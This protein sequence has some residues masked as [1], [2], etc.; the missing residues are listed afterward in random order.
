MWHHITGVSRPL[1][2]TVVTD[3]WEMFFF[4]Q[5]VPISSWWI[6][7][8]FLCVE[9]WGLSTGLMWG[10]LGLWDSRVQQKP[11]GDR[12]VHAHLSFILFSGFRW[13]LP[14]VPAQWCVYVKRYKTFS[15]LSVFIRSVFFLG[16]WSTAL[17]EPKFHKSSCFSYCDCF[18]LYKAIYSIGN[19][20][21]LLVGLSYSQT[22]WT[23]ISTTCE[24]FWILF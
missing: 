6:C 8:L 21:M 12:L 2:Q 18:M 5:P 14:F 20:I 16:I 9:G 11:E 24:E 15:L 1:G 23:V 17:L 3:S 10:L 4:L 22:N 13:F 19:C 7:F